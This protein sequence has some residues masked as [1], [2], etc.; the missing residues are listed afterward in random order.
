VIKKYFLQFIVYLLFGLMA[1]ADPGLRMHL[2][3]G[4]IASYANTSGN[5]QI[6][7]ITPAK[8]NHFS[9]YGSAQKLLSGTAIVI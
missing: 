9:G 5:D 2:Q 3:A 4:D 1:M 8:S 7:I 6:V